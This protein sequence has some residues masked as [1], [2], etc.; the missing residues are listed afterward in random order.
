VAPSRELDLAIRCCRFAFADG[1]PPVAGA[2][3]DWPRFLRLVRFHRIQGLAWAALSGAA[4]RLPDNV[5]E[6]LVA[7]ASAIAADSLRATVDSRVMLEDL[8]PNPSD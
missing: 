1:K 2:E 4:D 3:L 8:Y 5:S 6:A 7:D